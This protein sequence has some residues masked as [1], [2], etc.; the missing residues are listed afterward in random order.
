MSNSQSILLKLHPPLVLFI[1]N[2]FH[3]IV[4][5]LFS[6][7]NSKSHSHLL[8]YRKYAFFD[9]GYNYLT[10]TVKIKVSL[11]LLQVSSKQKLFWPKDPEGVFFLDLP[12]W[13]GLWMVYRPFKVFGNSGKKNWNYACRID[14]YTCLWNLDYSKHLGLEDLLWSWGKLQNGYSF[15]L[16]FRWKKWIWK[17]LWNI[18]YI[19]QDGILNW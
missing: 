9:N 2:F 10:V 13:K 8:F 5:L 3:S 1:L 11:F 19:S 18:T 17:T 12:R 15:T 4:W 6:F 7:K 14:D 16:N